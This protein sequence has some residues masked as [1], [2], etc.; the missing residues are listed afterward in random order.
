[1]TEIQLKAEK[2]LTGVSQGKT[3]IRLLIYIVNT[4]YR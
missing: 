4:N 3:V 2:D 1:M